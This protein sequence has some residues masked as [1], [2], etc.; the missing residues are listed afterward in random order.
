MPVTRD[1]YEVLGVPRDADAADIKKAFRA[2][3]RE[4]HPDTSD[5]DDA[6]ELFKEL[7][8]AYEVL[9]DPGKR[10]NYDRFGSAGQPGSDFGGQ[11]DF[12]YGYGSPFGGGVGDLFSA[13]FGGATGASAGAARTQGR[14][15]TA[16]VVITLEEAASG[17]SKE[18]RYTRAAPCATCEGTGAAEGGEVQ[19][20]AQCNGTGQV[21]YQ[22]NT[23]F[24]RFETVH[25]CDKCGGTGSVV[26]KPCPTCAGQ[27]RTTS[28]ERVTVEIPAGIHDG[29]RVRV[30]EKGEAGFRGDQSGDLLVTVRVKA[31]DFL[32]REG[33][34]LH[35]RAAVPMTTAA[36][37]GEIEVPGLFGP[38]SVKVPNGTQ[39]GDMLVTKAAGMPNAQGG[40]G[41]LI[42][43]ANIV[44]PKKLK[45]EQRK[46]LE[47]LAESM[48]HSK[49]A[50]T[51]D[52]VRD[53]LGV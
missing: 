33:D 49:S 30:A 50:S 42:V 46:L 53:W 28:A 15:M 2:K 36:L 51:L 29:Q 12:G 45:K 17:V 31:H 48:G 24:G 23:F 4:V 40:H 14:D 52:R 1:Y 34:D 13:F 22:R 41:N 27:G 16:Q 8:E 35:A 19:T 21:V 6:E 26:D 18:V 7:N 9:S 10:A 20:C 47:Q 43:H 37:G 25:P 44:V 32:H 11:P 3:A 38:V 5:H 39:N